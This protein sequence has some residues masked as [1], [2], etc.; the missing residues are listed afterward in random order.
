MAIKITKSE[1]K[2]MIREALREELASKKKLHESVGCCTACGAVADYLTSNIFGENLCDDCWDE[3]IST[4]RG[5]VDL[6]ELVA[7]GNPRLLGTY[8]AHDREAE[9]SAA[10]NKYRKDFKYPKEKIARIEANYDRVIT[11]YLFGDI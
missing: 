8:N 3:F 4:E 10:W 9:V 11:N 7:K 2:Q 5:L 1:L 6:Y